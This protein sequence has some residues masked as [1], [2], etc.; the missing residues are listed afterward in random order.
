[1]GLVQWLCCPTKANWADSPIRE[2]SRLAETEAGRLPSPGAAR[3]GPMAAF[4]GIWLAGD[5]PQGN[6]S[7][8]V[9]EVRRLARAAGGQWAVAEALPAEVLAVE[10]LAV[11]LAEVRVVLA[12]PR[13][14]FVAQPRWRPAAETQSGQ[15]PV[16]R[17]RAAPFPSRGHRCARSA[18][19][20]HIAWYDAGRLR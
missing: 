20:S 15:S 3:P 4:R 18:S 11:V 13:E 16:D 19:C 14:D 17:L 6:H 2:G 5:P 12:V 10:T 7:P 9:G 1:M 8:T